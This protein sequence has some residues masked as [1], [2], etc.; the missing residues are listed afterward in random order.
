MDDIPRRIEQLEAEIA[1]L[2]RTSD[3]LDVEIAELEREL[4]EFEQRYDR[5]VGVV[6][7]RLDAAQAAVEDLERRV[8]LKQSGYDRA[9]ET[10]WDAPPRIGQRANYAP[11]PADSP[12]SRPRERDRSARLKTLYRLLARRFHPDLARDPQDYDERTRLMAMINE[13]YANGDLETLIQ[14]QHTGMLIAGEVTMQAQ[15]AVTFSV[16]RL[17]ELEQK[18]AH[19]VERIADQKTY[20]DSLA[21]GETMALKIEDSLARAKGRDLLREMAERMEKEYGTLM[22]RLDELRRRL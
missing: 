14:L 7:V 4:K 20:R 6:A 3:E 10:R 8:R 19:L 17:R 11:P 21:Y 15:K 1:Q 5:V 2:E 22:Q 13:A 9:P 16:L 12:S 18:R